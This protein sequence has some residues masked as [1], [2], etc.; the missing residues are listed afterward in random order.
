M[1]AAVPNSVWLLAVKSILLLLSVHSLCAVC[2]RMLRV[3]HQFTR[4]GRQRNAN[5]DLQTKATDLKQ[6]TDPAHRQPRSSSPVDRLD[7]NDLA[8][9]RLISLSIL[10]VSLIVSLLQ[11][12]VVWFDHFASICCSTAFAL[13]ALIGDFKSAHDPNGQLNLVIALISKLLFGALFLLKKTN[14]YMYTSRPRRRFSLQ[15]RRPLNTYTVGR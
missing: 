7:A 6:E 13:I 2:L 15:Q 11:I 3:L 10:S 14:L 9:V 5:D 12:A 4:F 1:Q 8:Q